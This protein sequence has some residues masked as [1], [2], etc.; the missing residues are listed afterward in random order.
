[1]QISK[2]RIGEILIERKLI[3]EAQLKDALQEQKTSGGFLGHIMV[4]RGW[5]TKTELSEALAEQFGI[6]LVEIKSQHI[7]MELVRRFSSCLILDYQCL[8]L[9]EDEDTITVAI[10]NPLDAAAISRIEEAVKP[11]KVNLVMAHEEDIRKAIQ[12]YRQNI[13]DSIRRLLKKKKN[14]E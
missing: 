14:V 13:S 3:T 7:D 12:Q 9:C 6:P 8:P 11:R 5:I 1:M 2:K 4:S 10:V